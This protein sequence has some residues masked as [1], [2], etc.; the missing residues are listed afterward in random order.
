[1]YSQAQLSFLKDIILQG[2]PEEGRILLRRIRRVEEQEQNSRRWTLWIGCG[3][4]GFYVVMALAR[5]WGWLWRQSEHLLAVAMLWGVGI[6]LFS[7]LMVGG[8]WLWHRC[9]LRRLISD[10]QRFVAGWLADDDPIE[11]ASGFGLS[12]WQGQFPVA[13][14]SCAQ[15]RDGRGGGATAGRRTPLRERHK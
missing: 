13:A 5:G 1:V 3:L 6:A 10:T 12:R 7:L 2:D 11:N 8:C 15:R 9:T 14:R 4:A